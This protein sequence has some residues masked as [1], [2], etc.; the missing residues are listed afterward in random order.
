MSQGD[1]LFRNASVVDVTSP[2]APPIPV[3]FLANTNSETVSFT[4]DGTALLFDTGQRTEA[5]QVARVDLVP[6]V[7]K[8]K[9]SKFRELFED[10][11]KPE[12]SGAT[13]APKGSAPQGKKAEAANASAAGK[14]AGPVKP[15]EVVADGIRT[16]LT[17]LPVAVDVQSLLPSPD[18]KQLLLVAQAEGAQNLYL[19]SL[20]ELATE[21]AVAK[22]LTATRGSKSSPCFSPDG[23]TIYYLDDGGVVSISVDSREAKPIAISASLDVDFDVEKKVVFDQA[24]GW[25]G[26]HFHD[27]KMNG[28]DWP[29]VR[30]TWAPHVAATRTPIELA[31]LLSMM[32]GELNASHLGVAP[33]GD[34]VRVTGRLGLRFDRAEY[35]KSG[36][37]KVAGL[38]P[39]TPAAVTRKIAVGEVLLAVNGVALTPEMSLDQLLENQVGREVRLTLAAAAGGSG[40]HDVE[41]LPVTQVVEKNLIYREWV[42]KNRAAVDKLSAGRLG[43]VHMIDMSYESLLR[44]MSDL[45]V[46]NMTREGV[47]IDVRNNSGGFVNAYALDILSRKH[48]LNMTERGWP[49]AN[50]RTLLGQRSLEKPTVLL[51]NQ[52]SLSDAEDFSEGYRTVG[53][54][55][56]VGEPTAGWIIYTSNVPM[57]DGSVVRLPSTTITTAR[58]EPMEMHPR[59]VDIEVRRALGEDAQSRDTQI[60]RAVT[61]L[62]ARVPK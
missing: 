8:F 38:V 51:T 37:L 61:E 11:P 7:P 30:S 3:S 13:P 6:R 46:Q 1:R 21:P 48:Y 20:D 59:P 19:Y 17:L 9:E 24:W 44:L 5:G 39:L 32:V 50:A 58:G 36:T 41:V 15:V 60:E 57:I 22:Q 12:P 2:G 28:A 35:E 4:P 54:G 53:L 34:P 14:K 62:L 25:L 47:V 45:D 18:G 16:R 40:K 33:S 42:E 31:R 43:Y 26:T 29:A 52:H 10:K 56:I 55:P 49:T 23:K 27:P